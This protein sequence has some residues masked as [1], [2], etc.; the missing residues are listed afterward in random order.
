MRKNEMVK[1]Y[2]KNAYQTIFSGKV[3]SCEKEKK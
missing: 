1:L 2:E 3:I